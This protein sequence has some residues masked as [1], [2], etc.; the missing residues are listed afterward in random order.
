MKES[1]SGLLIK[2]AGNIKTLKDLE[3]MVAA[4]ADIIG[5]SYSVEIVKEE[6]GMKFSRIHSRDE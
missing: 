2:A 4:G 5:S 1:A 3:M 6:K